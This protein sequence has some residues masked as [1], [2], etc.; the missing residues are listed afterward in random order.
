MSRT[1]NL[2][3]TSLPG[4][5][6]LIALLI[7]FL[8]TT[9]SDHPLYIRACLI[10]GAMFV[11]MFAV[12]AALSI[13]GDFGLL[14]APSQRPFDLGRVLIKVTGW[15]VTVSCVAS[16]YWIFP[17]YLTS[18]YIPYYQALAV[19]WPYLA[20]FFLFCI[21]WEDV[22]GVKAHDDYYWVGYS[23]LCFKFDVLKNVNLKQHFLA[24]VVKLYFLPLMF[25]YLVNYLG[26]HFNHQDFWGSYDS[27][28]NSIYLV[29]TAFVCVG[30]V[31][32]NNLTDTQIRSSDPTMLGWACCIICYQPIWSTIGSCY[33]NYGSPWGLWLG[34]YTGLR[35]IWAGLIVLCWFLYIWATIS[36]GSRFSNLTH[37][38]ILTCGPYAYLRHPAY[39]GKLASYFLMYIPFVG[40]DLITT[41]RYCIIWVLL[42]G[43]YYLRARTE[44]AHLR[45]L[46]PEYDIYAKQVA[47]NWKKLVRAS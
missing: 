47:E 40:K 38:G 37:R 1:R 31:F 46:G 43:V 14:S 33:L 32:A 7:S 17:E 39:V 45:S 28:Y 22:R 4:W 5:C 12:E 19:C 41:V 27:I 42:A 16:A 21:L 23:L 20:G 9:N 15:V 24:W 29:D 11:V 8:A 18:F 44:E 3:K 13:W 35:V 2:V 34:Q 26:Y 6:G 36:F 25:I 30:Y 10:I